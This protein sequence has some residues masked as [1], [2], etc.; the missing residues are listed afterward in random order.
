[1]ERV[2]IL[3]F[4]F[5]GFGLLLT[6]SVAGYILNARY[7]KAREIQAKSTILRALKPIGILSPIALALMLI[8]GIGNMHMLGYTFTDPPH[9]LAYKLSLFVLAV[10][11]GIVFAVKSRKRGALIG[12]LA[13]GKTPANAL[14]TIQSYDRQINVFYLV[15]G[16]LMIMILLLSIN[17]RLGAQ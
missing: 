6:T 13:S 7:K 4:H 5:I 11:G 3:F 2:I 16:L 17:G 1:M 8:T 12:E 14:E 15:L 10:I 9:W